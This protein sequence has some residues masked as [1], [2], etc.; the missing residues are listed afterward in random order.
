VS[1]SSFT[2]T[3]VDDRCVSGNT[4]PSHYS[5]IDIEP[6]LSG[7][8]A[9]ARIAVSDMPAGLCDLVPLARALAWRII[10]DATGQAR[11]SGDNVPCAKGCAACCSY[12]VPL[13][14]PEALCMGRELGSLAESSD[15]I[16]ARALTDAAGKILASWHESPFA[17]DDSGDSSDGGDIEAVGRWY[18][19]LELPCA[20]LSEGACTIYDK[21]PLACREHAVL[22]TSAHCQGFSPDRGSRLELPVNILDAL[23]QVAAD[24]EQTEVQAVMMPLV[25]FWYEENRHRTLQT[26]DGPELVSKFLNC[27]SDTAS[28]PAS[29]SEAA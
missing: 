2:A 11:D 13:S 5:V 7:P 14:A 12:L 26:W 22:G 4:I 19:S 27:L 29:V 16:T 15:Q 21:R 23:G 3:L 1:V 20:F 28:Q 6:D 9:G 10:D 18:A 17:Q 8:L 24:L 25:P